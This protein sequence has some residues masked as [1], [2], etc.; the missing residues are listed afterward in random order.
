MVRLRVKDYINK[1]GLISPGSTV[2]AAVSGGP[3]SVAFTELFIM[4]RPLLGPGIE[5]LINT[6]F[7]SG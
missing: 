7:L 1:Y 3:D 5:P 2:I 4:T 6:R